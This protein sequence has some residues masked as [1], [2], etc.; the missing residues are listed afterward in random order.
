MHRESVGGGE[1]LLLRR[2]LVEGLR[3]P[4]Q[5]LERVVEITSGRLARSVVACFPA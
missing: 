2:V 4:L 5:R 3:G 1:R